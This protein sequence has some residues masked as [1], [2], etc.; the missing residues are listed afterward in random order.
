MQQLKGI[1]KGFILAVCMF[2]A[3]TLNTQNFTSGKKIAPNY[4]GCF[5]KTSTMLPTAAGMPG[6]SKTGRLNTIQ[7]NTVAVIYRSTHSNHKIICC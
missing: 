5:L 2:C 6:W 3:V 7:P 4:S 1:K